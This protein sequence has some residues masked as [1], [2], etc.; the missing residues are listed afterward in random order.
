MQLLGTIKHVQIQRSSLKVG[1]RPNRVF[2]PAPLL[3]VDQLRLTPTGAVGLLADGA[4]VIDVH[5]LNHPATRNNGNINGLSFNFTGHYAHMLNQFGTH[6]TSGIAGENI[7]IDCDR[8][9]ALD[10]LGSRLAIQNAVDGSTT[11][12]DNLMVA[13]PC[14]EFSCFA[15]Q[16]T[17]AGE[18]MK[19]TLQFLDN[20]IR[21]FY[22]TL[23]PSDSEP[24]IKAGDKVY[25]L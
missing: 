20:G 14:A 17:I 9:V 16:K 4:S 7:L 21:G 23:A 22:A 2:D 13:A 19:N 12:L 3:V 1:E 25:T 18:E 5:N 10:E 8:L 24:T 11:Y 15:S 6:M